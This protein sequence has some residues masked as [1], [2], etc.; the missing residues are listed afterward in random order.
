MVSTSRGSSPPVAAGLAASGILARARP[1][2]SENARYHA[3]HGSGRRG[4][5]APEL[6]CSADVRQTD[7]LRQ[8]VIS[9]ADSCARPQVRWTSSAPGPRV[10]VSPRGGWPGL[11]GRLGGTQIPA[12][13]GRGYEEIRLRTC[14]RRCPRSGR[15]SVIDCVLSTAAWT[16]SSVSRSPQGSYRPWG[17]YCF[18]VAQRMRRRAPPETVTDR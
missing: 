17:L 10:E 18:W 16:S 2:A 9:S 1:S 15:T 6:V 4:A 8:P 13:R 14:P 5:A 3:R 7:S 12:E 11:I